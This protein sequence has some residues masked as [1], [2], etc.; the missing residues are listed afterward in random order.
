M[1]FEERKASE[2]ICPLAIAWSLGAGRCRGAQCAAWTWE[3]EHPV[4]IKVRYEDKYAVQEPAEK[5][6]DVGWPWVPYC[7]EKDNWAGWREPQQEA[8]ARATGYC[9]MVR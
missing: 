4:P 9:G 2:M 5:P 3:L 7:E 1:I 6:A 8:N